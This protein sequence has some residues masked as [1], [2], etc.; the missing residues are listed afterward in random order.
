MFSRVLVLFE[1][2]EIPLDLKKTDKH[3]EDLRVTTKKYK[4]QEGMGKKTIE[5]S[6][7]KQNEMVKISTDE[8]YL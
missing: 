8:I 2:E 1:K 3:A 5:K 4:L 6:K 7:S